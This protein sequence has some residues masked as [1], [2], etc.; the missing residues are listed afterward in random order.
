LLRLEALQSDL[1]KLTA[2]MDALVAETASF[3][4]ALP[5]LQQTLLQA[6]ADLCL[7]HLARPQEAA[8]V[9]VRANEL[10]AASARL[11]DAARRFSALSERQT[12]F[13]APLAP[14]L[15]FLDAS[16]AAPL[17]HLRL[18]DAP[19]RLLRSRRAAS[20]PSVP[21]PSCLAGSEAD[22][23]ALLTRALS[24]WESVNPITKE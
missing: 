24:A 15:G 12:A 9:R 3:L 1:A 8:A 5:S 21:S 14:L 16:T 7:L 11:T 19:K 22:Y 18:P 23:R 20:R 6:E 2:R 4:Q 13:A 10:Q 17:D